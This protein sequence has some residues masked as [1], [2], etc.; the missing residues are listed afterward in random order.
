MTKH[1]GGLAGDAGADYDTL[2]AQRQ[3]AMTDAERE[4]YDTAYADAGWAME[5]AELVYTTRTQAGLTQAQLAAAM[6]TS[7][8]AIAAWENGA[9]TPGIEALERLARAC[10]RKLH[11]TI[12]AA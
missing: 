11:I 7:Q 12:T 5:L 10:G 2:H 4:I 1:P 9:R 3:A 6:G 8:S